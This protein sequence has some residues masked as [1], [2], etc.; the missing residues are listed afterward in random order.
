MSDIKNCCDKLEQGKECDYSNPFFFKDVFDPSYNSDPATSESILSLLF[1]L[2][3]I[4]AVYNLFKIFQVR[5][6]TKIQN[7]VVMNLLIAISQL[8]KN[9]HAFFFN[10]LVW[11]IYSLDG[12]IQLF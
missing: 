7:M 9:E 2:V 1:L 10:F 3:G 5:E 12:P 11:F 8:S 4:A 6:S